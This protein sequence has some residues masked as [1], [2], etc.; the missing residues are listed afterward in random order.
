VIDWLRARRVPVTVAAVFVLFNGVGFRNLLGIPLYAAFAVAVAAATVVALSGAG[1]RPPRMPGLLGAFLLVALASILWSQTRDMTAATL[2]LTGSLT[3]LALLIYRAFSDE[4]ILA[5]FHRAL[6][7]SVLVGL[8]FEVLVTA[9]GH[10]ISALNP[11][12]GLAELVPSAN[13]SLWSEDRLLQ[14]GPIQGFVGNRNGFGAIALLALVL[15][16]CLALE[17]TIS[18]ADALLTLVPAIVALTLTRSATISVAAACLV[19]LGA[20]AALMRR[21]SDARKRLVSWS[22][23]AFCLALGIL[24]IRFWGVVLAGLDRSTD[25]TNRG[26]IWTEVAKYALM[27]PEGWGWVSAYWPTWRWPYGGITI[28]DHVTVPH[29]HNA[30]IEAWMELGIIGAA[31]MIGLCAWLASSAWR[32]TEKQH[33]GDSV[34]PVAWMLTT[35]ALI[36]Q[37]LTESRLYYEGWWVLFVI[38]A[39]S[40]PSAFRLIDEP[41][42]PT[43]RDKAETRA[44]P[45]R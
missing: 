22:F 36:I 24:V 7:A 21:V 32:L 25:L 18:R 30:F 45:V 23:I 10:P 19:I 39:A 1:V 9:I 4:T 17:R 44:A 40:V 26:V 42:T 43:R 41:A 12:T 6:Q 8:A 14:G 20:G 34:I 5:V 28:Q 37:S 38:L 31:L 29:A 11:T 15:A 3:G 16:C 13:L 27:R 2:L 33:R 35:A